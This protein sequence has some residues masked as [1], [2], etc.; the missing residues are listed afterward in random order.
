[1]NLDEETVIAGVAAGVGAGLSTVVFFPLELIKTKLQAQVKHKGEQR[2][3]EPVFNGF[4]DVW[5]HLVG[6]GGVGSLFHGLPPTLFRSVV[7]DS[8][9]FTLSTTLVKRVQQRLGRELVATE[10]IVCGVI[11]ACATQLFVHPIDTVTTKILADQSESSPV[12]LVKRIYRENGIAGFWKGYAA[13]MIL[14][15]NPALQFTTFDRAK[16]ACLNKL[17]KKELT[18]AQLFILGMVT[19]AF[20]LT[21]IYPLIRA[22]VRMQASKENDKHATIVSSF[23]DIIENEGVPGLYKGLKEQIGKSTMSTAL[24][25]TCK[26]KIVYLITKLLR[27]DNIRRNQTI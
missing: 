7:C 11:S 25:L 3:E 4:S 17:N 9:Y 1:M 21:I 14:S 13:S 23:A 6:Q 26:E 27:R 20:T 24:L 15:L 16:E 12:Q 8:L 10:A 5:T 22:K 19:K 18:A 2:P